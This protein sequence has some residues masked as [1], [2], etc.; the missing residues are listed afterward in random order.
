[1]K[2]TDKI[3]EKIDKGKAKHKQKV[4]IKTEDDQLVADSLPSEEDNSNIDIKEIVQNMTDPEIK[5]EVVKN[6]FE[7]IIEQNN[8]RDTLKL[9]NDD[10]VLKLLEEN[11][12]ELKKQEKIKFAIEAIGNNDKKLKTVTKNIKNLTDIELANILNGLKPEKKPERKEI[13]EQQKI[14]IVSMKI[15]EHI[16]KHGN[17]WHLGELTSCLNAQGKI[18]VGDLC[19]D[20]I[21]SFEKNKQKNINTKVKTKFLLDLYRTIDID[22]DKKMNKMD[23]YESDGILTEEESCFI[24]SEMER[25]RIEKEEKMQ[26]QERDR[27]H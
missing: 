21:D 2:F 3:L 19:I 18:A 13:I 27:F 15:L 10:D 12:E 23:K 6:N 24:K 14:K 11:K 16:I 17:A 26:Q 22:Y 4:L 1:M 20:S 9:L 5:A 25:E 8:V 7:E